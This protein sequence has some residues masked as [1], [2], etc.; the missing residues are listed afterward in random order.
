[1][2]RRVL[3]LASGARP[4]DMGTERNATFPPV[5]T[6]DG[7]GH[8]ERPPAEALPFRG[9][10]LGKAKP[11]PAHPPGLYG[12]E[13]AFAALNATDADTSL[14]PIATCGDRITPAARRWRWSRSCWRWR[15]CC[16]SPMR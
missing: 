15:F 7:F 5:M 9:S 10:Q 11:S 3:D 14:D 16:S 2:L 12:S 8:L 13:G 4:A 1:M 6:L